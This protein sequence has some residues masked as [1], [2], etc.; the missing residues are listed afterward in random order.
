MYIVSDVQQYMRQGEPAVIFRLAVY[1][2]YISILQA[3]NNR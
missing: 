1:R 2:A 3:G